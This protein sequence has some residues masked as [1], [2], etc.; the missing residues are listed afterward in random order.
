MTA[1]KLNSGGEKKSILSRKRS[2]TISHFDFGFGSDM[3]DE[4]DFERLSDTA[5]FDDG[6]YC[7]KY[8][9]ISTNYINL[10]RCYLVKNAYIEAKPRFDLNEGR[11]N[12][13]SK[14]TN[15]S[16]H[17]N[18][19]CKLYRDKYLR[20]H[21]EDEETDN[22]INKGYLRTLYKI[23]KKNNIKYNQS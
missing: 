20:F 8:D 18:K 1:Q 13:T 12:R 9:K 22:K 4:D 5:F 19:G 10:I 15:F 17:A 21:S 6:E 7:F 3:A 14:L 23:K 16:D 11:R 2:K